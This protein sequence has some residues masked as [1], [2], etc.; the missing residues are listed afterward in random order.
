[1]PSCLALLLCTV[2]AAGSI[3]WQGQPWN[4]VLFIPCTAVLQQCVPAAEH[5]NRP[6]LLLLQFA[7]IGPRCVCYFVYSAPLLN[8]LSSVLNSCCWLCVRRALRKHS[9]LGG[10]GQLTLILLAL[11]AGIKDTWSKHISLSP[12]RLQRY[13]CRQN[14]NQTRRVASP[15]NTW[16]DL[17]ANS[18]VHILLLSGYAKTSIPPLAVLGAITSV[19][20][21]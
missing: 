5:S 12:L 21:S 8:I 16:L 17:E 13:M 7:S 9:K 6:L 19:K 10:S 14:G 20:R 18:T 15:Y 1:M 3:C 2:I 4:K 11:C